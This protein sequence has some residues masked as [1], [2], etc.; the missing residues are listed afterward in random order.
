[1]LSALLKG[2]SGKV[3]TNLSTFCAVSHLASVART[4]FSFACNQQTS[5]SSAEHWANP[6]LRFFFSLFQEKTALERLWIGLF[7][8]AHIFWSSFFAWFCWGG[9]EYSGWKGA[10]PGVCLPWGFFVFWANTLQVFLFY[11]WQ[12]LVFADKTMVEIN[13]LCTRFALF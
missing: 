11:Q 5:A 13:G 1:M 7:F 2:S 9:I 8:K 3:F 12:C 4:K 10:V 6:V